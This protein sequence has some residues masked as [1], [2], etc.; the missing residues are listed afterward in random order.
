MKRKNKKLIIRI[1]IVIMLAIY[2][3]YADEI[4]SY[5]KTMENDNKVY[6]K[7]E[8]VKD[9][10]ISDDILSIYFIDVGQADCILIR[11]KDSNML[12]DAGNNED[13]E[14]LVSYFKDLGIEKF[15]YVVGTHAHEDHIGGMDDII[16]NFH[17]DTFY[18]PDVITTTRTFEDVLDALESNGVA[19]NT[20][21][22]NKKFKF[23]DADVYTLY[24]GNDSSDLNN[25]SI[26][27][28]MV[29]R[30]NSFIF[31]G[32]ATSTVERKIL[33]KDLESDVLK[34]GHHG[35]SYSSSAAFLRKV[36]P[37]YSI[38]SVGKNNIYNHPNSITLKK[39][40][41]LN[42]KVYRTDTDGTIILKSDGK[43]IS[44]DMISTDTNG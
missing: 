4:N 7:R 37:K 40:E 19:F 27:L 9:T 25:T 8:T 28:K 10:F 32:D 33:D 38:I 23:A 34:V 15:E 26:V 31:T 20:P 30:A 12:I 21:E 11:N 6:Q 44:V 36:N 24:V 22:I 43:N 14:K 2:Y 3:I 17:I 1:F 29:Y 13:G 18:M 35:S 5:L 39:L 16:N 41:K 42:S